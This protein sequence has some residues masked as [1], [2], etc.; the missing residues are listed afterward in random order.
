MNKNQ[1]VKT[2]SAGLS[3][4][5]LRAQFEGHVIGPGDVGSDKA[6]TVFDSCLFR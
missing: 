1:S 5:K 2:P 4:E 6:R 3:V